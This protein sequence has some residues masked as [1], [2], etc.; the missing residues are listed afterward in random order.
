MTGLITRR[1]LSRVAGFTSAQIV[2]QLLAFASGIVLVRHMAQAQYGIYTLGISM[3]GVANVLLDLGLGTAVLASGGPLHRAPDRIGTVVADAWVLQRRLVALGS[4]VLVPAFAAMWA[5][6]GL[7]IVQVA[8][9]S[10]MTIACA[11]LTVRNAIAQSI[12]RLRNDL[13]L[14]QR[15]EIGVHTGKLA[16]V[17]AASLVL[18]DAQVAIALNL[19]ATAAMFWLLRQYLLRHLGASLLSTGEHTPAF[20]SYIRRQAPNSLYYCLSGQIAVFLVGLLGNADRVG[21]LGALGRLAVFFSIIGAVVAAFAQPY[22]ARTGSRRELID[23]FI[24]LNIGFW[25]LTTA[26]T[27]AALTR[28]Q[29]LLWILGP[30]YAG[31]QVEVVWMV[32]SASLGAWAAAIYSVGAAR[33]WVVPAR[34]N[35]TLGLAALGLSACLLDVSTVA[36][37]FMMGAAM[38]ATAL[39]V[40]FGYVSARMLESRDRV[41]A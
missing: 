27:T 9:L 31:L 19:A 23:A 10:L 37:G 4:F 7:S 6:Q 24:G 18:L 35:V 13:A 41:P 25:L 36:G 39:L 1:R 33:Q 28:P 3:L 20:F 15:L 12:V 22:F 26:L 8:S 17:V 29:V 30:R 5:W 34:L 32:L 38:S 2:L 11:A 14:Q 21:Q 40:A 16:V